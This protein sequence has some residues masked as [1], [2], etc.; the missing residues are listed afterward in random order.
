[1]KLDALCEEQ[2]N[3]EKE[4]E[5]DDDDEEEEQGGGKASDKATNENEGRSALISSSTPEKVNP[6]PLSERAFSSPFASTRKFDS[7]DSP[8]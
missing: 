1:M 8:W 6:L 2:A 3:E 5:E 7:I 4:E